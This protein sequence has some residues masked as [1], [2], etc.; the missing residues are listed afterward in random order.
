MNEQTDRE[1]REVER[2][3]R[4]V[5][6]EDRE[7]E[8]KL[9]Q[10]KIAYF[11]HYYRVTTIYIMVILTLIFTVLLFEVIRGMVMEGPG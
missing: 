9:E 3:Q 7:V 8:R 10:L 6:R 1:D 2:E 5:D 11:L 4:E